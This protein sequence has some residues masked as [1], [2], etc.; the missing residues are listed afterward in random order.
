MEIFFS[1][2]NSLIK[3]IDQFLE[4]ISQGNLLFREGVNHYLAGEDD[5]FQTK[6]KHLDDKEAMA[7]NLRRDA[8]NQLYAHSLIPQSRGDVLALLENMD[9][10]IDTCKKTLTQFDI[11]KPEIDESLQKDFLLL[12]EACTNCAEMIV[13]S[14][15]AF[16]RN[17]SNVKDHLHKVYHY[18]KEADRL[19][20][21]LKRKIFA[22]GWDLS[23]KIH[24][25]S[26]T[27][28]IEKISD[29][30]QQVADR[31]SIYTIKRSI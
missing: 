27:N 28:N 21:N 26:F 6:L 8:E 11:E 30:A 10:V 16:F 9:Y 4:S 17:I 22:Q 14:T 29:R 7:D 5:H 20:G 18:E 25:S 23:R 24:L 13:L 12:T 31:L 3:Q 15:G 1:K 19:S 2:T